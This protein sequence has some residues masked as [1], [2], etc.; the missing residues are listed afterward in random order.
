[1]QHPPYGPSALHA[2]ATI[3]ATN[4]NRFVADAGALGVSTLTPL[5]DMAS[6]SIFVGRI[7]FTLPAGAGH[8]GSLCAVII[9]KRANM[10]ASYVETDQSGSFWGAPLDD[11]SLRYPWL[12]MLAPIEVDGGFQED[13][14]AIDLGTR[15][16]GPVPFSAVVGDEGV[17][18]SDL[19]VVLV[20]IGND[21]QLYWATRVP[22]TK[23]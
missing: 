13:S 9:D 7:D 1:M 15:T 8:D 6:A 18:A 14:M 3:R 20:F 23:M 16:H 11:L 12:S 2:S 21:D 19:M 5:P 10:G 22:L 4:G 17:S